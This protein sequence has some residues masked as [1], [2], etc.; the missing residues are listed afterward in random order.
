MTYFDVVHDLKGLGHDIKFKYFGKMDCP[1]SEKE[2][3]LVFNFQTM[4]SEE[5]F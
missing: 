2:P 3:L 4:S 1:R 5:I